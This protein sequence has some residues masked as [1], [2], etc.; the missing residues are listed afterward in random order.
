M[1]TWSGIT[2]RSAQDHQEIGIRD[3]HEP[4][5]LKLGNA[6]L[7]MGDLRDA[8][9]EIGVPGKNYLFRGIFNS[10]EST[11]GSKGLQAK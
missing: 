10:E 8:N 9:R 3:W 4:H 11:R 6:N 7:L 2:S 1:L 5:Q